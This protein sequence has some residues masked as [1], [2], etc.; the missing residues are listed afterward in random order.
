MA[1]AIAGLST[2]ATIALAGTAASVGM[3]AYTAIS[4]NKAQKR[5]QSEL[6]RQAQN[7][8]LRKES[9][10]LNDYYQEALNRYN[11][12]PY[13]SA[14]Y[15]QAMRNADRTTAAGISA[16]QDRKGAIGGVTKLSR[17][18]GEALN[19]AILGGEYAR[20]QKFNQ[21]GQATQMKKRDE[22]EL[23]DINVMTPY[24]RKLQLEQMKGAAAGERYN[25]G[26]QMVGQGL[27]NALSYATNL[28]YTD[29]ELGK[30]IKTPAMTNPSLTSNSF[31]MPGYKAKLP[32]SVNNFF[33][34]SKPKYKP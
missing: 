18:K 2:A 9:K 22:D 23:F 6:E 12:N 14:A 21:L 17:L 28:E 16:L 7:N 33:Q 1:F 24:Q 13:Q 25:A 30:K 10:A 29:P 3:G 26:M 19:N 34:T 20:S 31:S 5:A 11:E 32:S 4:A 27:S 8:P 15:Q